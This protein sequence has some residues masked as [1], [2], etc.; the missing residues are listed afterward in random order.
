MPRGKRLLAS[1]LSLADLRSLLAAKEKM[2]A[3]EER[4]A[5]LEKELVQVDAALRQ[6][7]AG[8]APAVAR[9]GRQPGRRRGRK[10]GP[11]PKRRAGKAGRRAAAK[12]AKPAAARG[13]KAERGTGA[14]LQDVVVG[15][16]RKN[17]APMPFQDILAAITKQKLVK[18]RSKNFA[19]VLRR[20][21][22]TSTRV[23]R[24][25]RG[26]YAAAR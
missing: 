24:V 5:A 11:K 22:S 6:L 3:L 26:T 2:V 8:A 23:K 18:T 14:T 7:A 9:A 15:L 12:P 13:R 25:A 20:T 21:L 16:I 1:E 4:K 19:N 10:P 17:G